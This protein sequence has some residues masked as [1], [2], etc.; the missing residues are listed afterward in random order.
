MYLYETHCHTAAASACSRLCADDI[1]E[2][3]TANGYS[4][5][6]ITDHFLNG[7]TAVDR[8][9]PYPAQIRDFCRGFREVKERAKGRLQVFF[10]FECSFC[11]TDVL[12]YGWDE[13]QLL[14]HADLLDVPF[15]K[16]GSYCA[17]NGLLA[18]HAHPFRGAEETDHV[19]LS[20]QIEAVET[21]NAARSDLCNKLGAQ[22]AEAHKKVGI[23]GSDL[24]ARGQKMLSGLAFDE[25]LTS[26]QDFIE[27]VRRREGTIVKIANKLA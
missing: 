5:V 8:S 22:Y 1:V 2:L 23:G 10:G 17:E 27:R 18:V 12:V 6:F 20:P 19:R 11:G 25:K 14:A 9:L 26:E 4:G 3:Y 21:Y 15:E 16:F 7:N 24:H 13:V